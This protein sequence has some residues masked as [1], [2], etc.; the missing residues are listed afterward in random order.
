MGFIEEA[1]PIIFNLYSEPQQKFKL[2]AQGHGEYIPP[3]QHKERIE[4]YFDPLPFWYEPFDQAVIDTNEYPLHALTQRPA[5]MYHSWGSQN[6]WLRQI[7][8]TNRLYIPEDLSRINNIIDE[9]WVFVSSRNGK[10]KVRVKLMRGVNSKTI[11]TWN[12]IGK[13][14]GA[15]NL[16]DNAKEFTEGFLLN[17]LIDDLLPANE[18]NY[19]YSNSDPITGQA[20]WFDVRVKIEKVPAEE[21]NKDTIS[22]PQ[23]NKF[24]LPP[25]MPHRPNII[26]YSV[27]KIET[28]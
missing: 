10:I 15:W 3:D 21:Q 5:A 17:H 7:H 1:K 28:E 6:T 26:K 19:N 27:K 12:A 14:T 9:D 13:R 22:Q 8:G 16:D 23:F 2:S 18:H 25:T 24:R 20:A 11:W 4:K